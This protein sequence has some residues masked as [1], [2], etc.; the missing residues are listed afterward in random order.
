[1][2][3]IKTHC[4][5]RLAFYARWLLV[6]AAMLAKHTRLRVPH[7]FV[8]GVCNRSWQMQIGTGPWQRVRIDAAGRVMA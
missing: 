1:M 8:V 2:A 3:A 7:R 4:R 5:C 6:A